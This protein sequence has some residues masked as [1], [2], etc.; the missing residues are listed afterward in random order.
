MALEEAEGGAEGKAQ[1]SGRGRDRVL[2]KGHLRV[3]DMWRLRCQMES[4]RPVSRGWIRGLPREPRL[5]VQ[6]DR[7][8]CER[9]KAQDGEQ[10]GPGPCSVSGPSLSCRRPT[11]PQLS[12]LTKGSDPSLDG[13]RQPRSRG[14]SRPHSPGHCNRW[15]CLHTRAHTACTRT[16]VWP[17]SRHPTL[18][19]EADTQAAKPLRGPQ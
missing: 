5:A 16:W 2:G 3:L 8:S 17:L 13:G 10:A 11:L 4:S 19:S 12:Q 1:V 18:S 9:N 6:L 15:W 14:Q 7:A